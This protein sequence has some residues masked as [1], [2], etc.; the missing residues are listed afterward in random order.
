MHLSKVFMPTL[1]EIPS[2]VKVISHALMLRAGF[3]RKMTS[4]VYSYLPLGLR[5]FRKISDIIRR[6]MDRIG[7]QECVM[8]ILVPKDV[9]EET[10]RWETFKANLFRLNDR[11]DSPFALGPTHEEYFTLTVKNNIQSYKDLPVCLY[12]IYTKFRDE[13]RPRFGVIRGKE[14]T[15]KDAYSFHLNDECLDKTYKDMSIAY[16]RIFLYSG[17]DTVAV[18]ADSGAMGGEG[19]EEFMVLSHI[20]ENDIAFCSSCDYKA[21]VEKATV[22]RD[23]KSDSYTDKP[24]EEMHTPNVITIEDL[25]NTYG[26]KKESLIKTLLLTVETGETI[27]V[28]IRGDIELNEV[29]LSNHLGGLEVAMADAKT[30]EEV[31]GARVGF[32]GPIGL[33]KKVRIIADYS[34]ESIYSAGVG[35]NKDDT[36]ITSVNIE[37]DFTIDEWADLRT[38]KEGD[39]CPNCSNTLYV[40]KGLELGHI[41]KLGDKY[42]KSYGLDIIDN[43][44]KPVT[45]TMGCYGIGVDRLF[46]GIIEQHNDDKG[47]IFPITIAPYEVSIIVIDTKDSNAMDFANKIHD[48]LE[49]KNVEVLLDDTNERFGVK[50]NNADLIGI[51]MRV[52][53]GK[54][55]MEKGV[56][57]FKL[58][59]DS[60]SIEVKKDDI[61]DYI[62]NTK[63]QLINEIVTKVNSVKN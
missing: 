29:K 52:V 62:I 46:A 41:F 42:S 40:K 31:T 8:P 12:Q 60:E 44:G 25:E 55:E 57:S 23:K 18:K 22:L 56:V 5:V 34:I 59:R 21:N 35:G 17:L 28:L 16:R 38:A 13:T 45:V 4:G 43:T 39:K 30:V 11:N 20:G 2:D 36:H 61:V 47:I 33:K 9:L 26:F 24:Y 6:E 14:F 19:S 51:P 37:R 10:G 1:K 48:E 63:E 15:M 3:V 7:S 49:S 58:R 53:I 27:A 32:A 50:L 54:K